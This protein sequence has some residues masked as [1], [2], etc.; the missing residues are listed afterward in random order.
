MAHWN[1]VEPKIVFP[2]DDFVGSKKGIFPAELTN[3]CPFVLEEWKQSQQVTN[4][5]RKKQALH[6]YTHIDNIGKN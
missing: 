3:C 1:G 5:K 4:T 6:I 2:G